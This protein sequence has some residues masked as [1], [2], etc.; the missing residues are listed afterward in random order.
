MKQYI[1]SVN[2]NLNPDLS[3]FSNRDVEADKA[4]RPLGFGDFQGQSAVLE[5]L[6]VFVQAASKREEAM[7]QYFCM[8]LQ[9]WEK[10]PYPISSPMNSA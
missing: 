6:E 10:Q 7:D 1:R 4:L 5:N 3:N 8:D 2:P 9:D